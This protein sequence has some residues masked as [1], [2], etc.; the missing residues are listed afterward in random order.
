MTNTI[1]NKTVTI[2]A[3]GFRRNLMAY[4]RRMEWEGRTYDFID[5][6]LACVV[7]GANCA[8]QILTLTDGKAQFHLRSDS[9]GGT[10][11]LLSISA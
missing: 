4:P 8:R 9:Q 5:A 7:R 10:W 2:T 3:M 11:T 1:I 6:G